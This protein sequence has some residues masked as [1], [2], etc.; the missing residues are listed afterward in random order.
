[1]TSGFKELQILELT[2]CGVTKIPQSF[3]KDSKNIE[4]INLSHNRI[5]SLDD[6]LFKAQKYLT[7]LN[8]NYNQIQIIS[9]LSIFNIHTLKTLKLSHNAITSIHKNLTF[10]DLSFNGIQIFEMNEWS[11]TSRKEITINLSHNFIKELNLTNT[12]EKLEDLNLSHNELSKI[13]EATISNIQSLRTLRLSYN[14]L[15]NIHQDTFY[16]LQNLK[17][18][19]LD[20]NQ[21]KELNF[22]AAKSHVPKLT[23]LVLANNNINTFF[24]MNMWNMTL[25]D[26]SYNK[27]SNY[28]INDWSKTSQKEITINLSHNLIDEILL[29]ISCESKVTL[30]L[31]NNPLSCDCRNAKLVEFLNEG[32]L[33]FNFKMDF[34]ALQCGTK[35]ISFLKPDD[36][37][38]N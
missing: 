35:L 24:A 26:L 30:L 21:L 20:N 38:I 11:R 31:D 25:L 36:I 9:E 23:T 1:M 22:A 15:Q 34:G 16:N 32:Q 7:T 13:T 12:S 6:N 37:C 14:A 2:N 18:L 33:R 17:E 19:Y 27:I 8:L 5:T 3:Y 4:E 29:K 28:S 10:L